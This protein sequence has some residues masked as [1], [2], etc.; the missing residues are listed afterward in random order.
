MKYMPEFRG[1]MNLSS[2]YQHVGVGGYTLDSPQLINFGMYV[3]MPPD[4]IPKP[5][6][7]ENRQMAEPD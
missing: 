3:P 4:E 1:D 5:I 7:G 2:N 6:K